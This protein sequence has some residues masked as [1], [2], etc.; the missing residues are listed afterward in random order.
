MSSCIRDA[1]VILTADE[2]VD[3]ISSLAAVVI[4]ANT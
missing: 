2:I 1:I 4:G 3:A